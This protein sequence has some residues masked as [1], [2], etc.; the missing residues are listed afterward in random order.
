MIYLER[1][2]V[3]LLELQQDGQT[4]TQGAVTRAVLWFPSRAGVDGNSVVFDTDTDS[5]ITLEVSQTQVRIQ[6]GQRPMN[7]G[8]YTAYLTIYDQNHPNGI[9]WASVPTRVRVWEAEA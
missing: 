1:D 4:V 5:D 9:A 2:N 7:P 8:V 6:A 3:I